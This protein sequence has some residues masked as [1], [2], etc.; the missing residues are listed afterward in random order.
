MKNSVKFYLEKRKGIVTNMPIYLNV[1]FGGKRLNYYT[2]KRCD[3][4]QW[5]GEKITLKKNCTAL[6]GQSADDFNSDLDR[7]KI[8]VKD[9]FKAYDLK[10]IKPEV[11]MVRD[12]LNIKLG[13]KKK[14]LESDLF[15]DRFQQ[16][17]DEK[18]KSKKEVTPIHSI[19]K[20]VKK[21]KPDLSFET[22]SVKVL[23]DLHNF[24][25][26]ENNICEN[27]ASSYLLR[28]RGFLKYAKDNRWT[29][30]NPFEHFKIKP[31]VYGD[32]VYLTLEERDILYNANIQ[33]TKL[34]LIRDMFVLQSLIL[35]PTNI[36]GL[37]FL[38]IP[39]SFCSLN[40][41]WIEV[42]VLNE[43]LVYKV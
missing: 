5:T 2:G 40:F 37:V 31:V 33:D 19:M 12:D 23:T 42:F 16:Y 24:M 26:K 15:F 21:F 38:Y 32:P 7:I 25:V 6:N 17:A 30:A 41:Q 43:N 18:N 9:L 10:K 8:A 22:L 29:D 14:R 36:F 39:I 4:T 27:S 20:Q 13:K 11:E 1:T 28:L 34:A 35:S 3:L